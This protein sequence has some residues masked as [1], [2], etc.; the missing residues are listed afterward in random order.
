MLDI[1]FY[2]GMI[3]VVLSQTFYRTNPCPVCLPATL[4]EAS[5]AFN[6]TCGPRNSVRDLLGEGKAHHPFKQ[7]LLGEGVRRDDSKDPEFTIDKFLGSR[8]TTAKTLVYRYR[9]IGAT[10]PLAAVRC[11]RGNSCNTLLDCVAAAQPAQQ[12]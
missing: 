6:W 1:G 4:A 10:A 5:R 11:Q 3:L 12:Q 2:R 7:N 9:K 8:Q